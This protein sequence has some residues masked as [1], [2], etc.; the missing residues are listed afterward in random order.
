[1]KKRNYI[2]MGMMSS[3]LLLASCNMLDIQPVGKVI[4]ETLTEYRALLA[5]AYKEV[6]ADR[7]LV[8]LRADEMQ[9]I[10][11]SWELE[12]YGKI[13]SWDDY[14][15]AG[16]TTPFE[17]ASYYSTLFSANYIIEQQNNITE[18]TAADIQQ[19]VGESYLLRAYTHFLL[20]NQYGQPYTR[21]GAVDTQAIPL[22]V[23]SDI[24]EVLSRNTVGEV[25]S[26]ILADIDE[27]EKRLNKDAWDVQFSYRFNALSVAAFRSRIHLYMGQWA[28]SYEAS[29][30]VLT[31]KNTLEDFNTI[32]Y[33]LP[34]HFQSVEA[35]VALDRPL[36]SNLSRGA[37]ASSVLLNSYAEGDLRLDVYIAPA[38]KKGYRFSKKSGKDEY[39]CTFRVGEIYLNAAEAAAHL[40]QLDQARTRL[41]QLMQKRYTSEAYAAKEVAINALNKEAL[42][43][44]ILNERARELAFEGHRWFDL[45]R[46]TRPRIEKLLG[47][48]T[49]ILEQDDARYTL[50]IP[51][52]AIAANPGLA[53]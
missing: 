49:Y 23:N 28:A 44:E 17:W 12:R 6:P 3:L 22:K 51:R 4:P 11:D 46:T 27:A 15:P 8:C 25:Y 45:R 24:N 2:F 32:T 10:K 7:G 35:I 43:A 47:G 48:K 31:S 19:L 1:M 33:R 41:L 14:A 52:A 36:T 50:P 26:S 30:N 37:S 18:G 53:N 9:V 38:D 42:I 13:E 40:N 16:T 39:R 20:V 34:N 21:P 29:E 5:T